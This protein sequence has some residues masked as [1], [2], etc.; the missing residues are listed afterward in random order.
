MRYGGLPFAFFVFTAH[1]F[2]WGFCLILIDWGV[3]DGGWMDGRMDI[4][5]FWCW[6]S[7]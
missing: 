4:W 5:G 6:V 3:T 2:V 1:C 7:R